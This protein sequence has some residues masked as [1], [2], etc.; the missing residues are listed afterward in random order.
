MKKRTTKQPPPAAAKLPPITEAEFQSQV[1]QLARVYDWRVC[2]FRPARVR[3][4]GRDTWRT[5]I[6]GDA[7]FPDLILA[8]DGVVIHAE[9]KTDRGRVSNDQTDWLSAIGSSAVVW[10]PRDLKSGAI[11]ERMAGVP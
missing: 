4:R 3:V 2:H 5:P 11:Q 10:R 9:L 1:I 6:S 7:G 8:R